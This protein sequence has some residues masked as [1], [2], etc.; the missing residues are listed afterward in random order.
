MS[1]RRI[2][3]SIGLATLLVLGGLGLAIAQHVQAQHS[4]ATTTLGKGVTAR[5]TGRTIGN[6]QLVAASSI[7]QA[8]ATDIAKAHQ[9][10]PFLTPWGSAKFAQ[11]K[12][13]A[14][15]PNSATN[16]GHPINAAPPS[17]GAS[18]SPNVPTRTTTFGGIGYTGSIPS[19]MG[20]SAGDGYVVQAVDQSFAVY[21]TSG[22]VQSGWPKTAQ[23][24]FGLT[25]HN[26]T[27]PRVLFDPTN[28]GHFWVLYNDYSSPTNHWYYQVAVS[29]TANP[30]SSWYIYKNSVDVIENSGTAQ[31]GFADLPMMGIDA[32]AVYFTGNHYNVST[33]IAQGAF[34]SWVNKNTFEAG[35]GSATIGTFNDLNAGDG[36]V[37]TLAPAIS[38]GAPR[39]ELMVSVD[40]Y[41]TNIYN[42]YA[43]SNPL[44]VGGTTAELWSY[45]YT[46]ISYSVP[47][48]AL[49]PGDTAASV[50]SGYDNITAS[51]VWRD[52]ILTFTFGSGVTQGS[53]QYAGVLFL[54]LGITLSDGNNTSCYPT[55]NRCV[56]IDLVYGLENGA[57]QY[58]GAYAIDPSLAVDTDGNTIFTYTYSST[59]RY[60]SGV[61]YSRRSTTDRQDF[62]APGA[63]YGLGTAHYG[64]FYWG[65]YSAA[66]I[67]AGS[68]TA[69][70]CYT[71]WVASDYANGSGHWSTEL[72]SVSYSL[73]DV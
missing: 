46:N 57:I 33:D 7:P 61:V 43:L 4:A 60:P 18:K 14:N 25:G 58:T 66:A 20:L 1:K 32:E 30:T 26:L 48:D 36:L 51:P 35:S 47:P 41:A 40:V 72:T 56:S 12:A 59:S 10:H 64:D 69:A 67:D 8:T 65:A 45:Q 5:P 52:G 55:T 29:Q 6:A 13:A 68:C 3:S 63:T 50:S 37:D 16:F 70:G 38:F 62:G 17:L 11:I 23:A 28:G 54:R 27:Q 34:V 9:S 19:N 44:F 15:K 39:A 71:V 21:N 73:G 53:T 49:Q 31:A 2:I 22:T 24:F 42:I